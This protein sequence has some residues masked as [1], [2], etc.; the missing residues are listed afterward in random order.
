[1][2]TRKHS[3]FV[4]LEIIQFLRYVERKI[5]RNNPLKRTGKLNLILKL[6]LLLF[7]AFSHLSTNGQQKVEPLTVGDRLPDLAFNQLINYSKASLKFSDFKNKGIILDFWATWCAPCL[8]QFP[9]LDSLQ[10]K[11]EKD[12]KIISVTSDIRP[13]VERAYEVLKTQTG[14]KLTPSIIFDTT[15]RKLFP[16]RIIPHY[17]WIGKDRIIKSITGAEELTSK[18]LEDLINDRPL[19]VKQ[20]VD[21]MTTE[22]FDY[23]TPP[24]RTGVFK[25]DK[26]SLIYNSVFGK[27]ISGLG[28]QHSFRPKFILF[29]NSPIILMYKFVFT[30]LYGTNWEFYD[31]NRYILVEFNK[32]DSLEFGYRTYKTEPDWL[33]VENEKCYNYELS[34]P[35]SITQKKKLEY[36]LQDLNRIFSFF[37]GF[38]AH[39]EK[40]TLTFLSLRRLSEKNKISSKGGRPEEVW[41]DTSVLYKN[42]RVSDFVEKL[43]YFC[44]TDGINL[45]IVDKT[46]IN[47]SY[48]DISLNL[49]NPSL[50]NVNAEL[51]EYDLELVKNTELMN[52]V[53]VKKIK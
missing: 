42:L 20:K 11:F 24:I 49:R 51:K 52:M 15:L 5:E 23:N 45:P 35:D 7:I 25:L 3:R 38:E 12:I 46:D 27:Y 19:L 22:E 6:V 10:S 28:T 1:M 33:K 36:V 40:R 44:Y 26:D 16:N 39:I 4:T 53:V 47:D 34:F 43:K 48:I 2:E 8:K 41:T 9:T 13:A 30:G 50:E 31:N 32:K 18:N 14:M 37:K 29:Q 17:V 21:D